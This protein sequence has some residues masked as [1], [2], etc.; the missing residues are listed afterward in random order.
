[1]KAAAQAMRVPIEAWREEKNEDEWMQSHRRQHA[2]YG[3]RLP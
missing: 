3:G 1:M 2:I